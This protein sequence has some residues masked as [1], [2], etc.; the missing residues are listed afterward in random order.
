MCAHFGTCKGQETTLGIGLCFP[1]PL[2]RVSC[3][4]LHVALQ[5]SGDCR[6]STLYLVI[7]LRFRQE[8]LYLPK[9]V[10]GD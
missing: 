6:V 3:S 1:C 8:L 10:V 9:W 5:A 7:V 4:L 2:D